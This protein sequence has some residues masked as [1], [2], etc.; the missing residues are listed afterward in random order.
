MAKDEQTE[1]VFKSSR[2]PEVDPVSGNEVPT[3]SLPEEVRDDIPAQLS[4]GEYV[5][6]AD[7]V[8]YYGVKF[9]EDLRTDA[10]D[11]WSDM[12][13]NGRIGGDPVEPEGMETV[14]PEDELP[15]DI[16]ELEVREYNE[17]GMVGSPIFNSGLDNIFGAPMSNITQKQYI[18]PDGQLMM[19]N[20]INGAPD[21][22]A[23]YYIGKGYKPADQAQTEPEVESPV[24]DAST[25]IPQV[26]QDDS[27]SYN[28]FNKEKALV[29]KTEPKFAG[30]TAQELI[31]YGEQLVDGKLGTAL[32]G[33]GMLNP[34]L[35]TL[36]GATRRAEV[37]NVAKGL[38]EKYLEAVNAG[39]TEEAEKIDRAFQGITARGKERGSGIA[40]G[41]GLLGGGGVLRDVNGDGTVDFFDTYV[42]DLLDGTLDGPNQSDSWNGARRVGG[43][44]TLSE[45]SL[46][47][48]YEKY[49]S[50]AALGTGEKLTGPA[51][52]APR[53]QADK[54]ATAKAATQSWVDA[55]QAV[56]AAGND[57]IARHKAV[58]AQSEASRAATQAIQASTG[59]TGFFDSG[60]SND[61]EEDE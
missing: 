37:F 58:L 20:F 24:S 8:R 56:E 26:S 13:E 12:E 17:G 29:E 48:Y 19:L 59:S 42:G 10:K 36:A 2:A 14:E 1:A 51:A 35:G 54:D 50:D 4:E 57:P 31:E 16:S 9:F 61:E 30:K 46:K 3:G 22:V 27:V 21:A 44:G 45:T 38:N 43:T 5:V 39:N 41:G 34:M 7:V 23:N 15:F 47:S 32:G 11:G 53:T 28:A 40:G 25:L 33:V 6:P 52:T 49:G 18:G 55:T 60:N